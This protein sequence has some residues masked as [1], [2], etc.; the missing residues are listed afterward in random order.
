MKDIVI[1]R[2]NDTPV[3]EQRTEM[4][5]RKGCGHPDSICDAVM[6][7]VAIALAHEYL[8]TFGR[9][10]HFNADKCLLVAGRSE[11]RVGGGTF[12]EPMRLVFGDR[13][14]AQFGNKR[15]D[16]GAVA[17]VAATNWLRRHLRYVDP[18]N[19]LVFQ[20]ELKEGSPELTGIFAGGKAK[21]NDTSVAVGYAPLSETERLVLRCERFLNSATFKARFPEVGEDVKVMGYRRDR[22]LALTVAVA[23]VDRFVPS[24]RAY[25]DRKQ[26]MADAV[27]LELQRELKSIERLAVSLNTLDDRA[28][29]ES[30][31]YLT[32]LGTSA[33][34]GDGGQVGRGNK[35]NGVISL[36][37]PIGTE[38]AAGKNPVSHVGKIYTLFTHHLASRIS[39][40][41]DG[42]CEAYVWLGS[43]IGAPVNEP[44]IFA[45]RLG[46]ETG[47]SLEDV[48]PSVA[49]AMGHGIASIDEFIEQL[50]R[51]EFPVC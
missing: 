11:P 17:E 48:R 28:A 47:C 18:Q 19:H 37:R 3:G 34:G 40:T 43:Q 42:V 8:K 50:V 29:G 32:V 16:P 46:L 36:N 27:T 9:V 10:L 25:F 7:D 22:D 21:A 1:E 6:E 30:G 12:V 31:I 13:A 39:A 5:E 44:A 4:V 35:V 45:A 38:A 23:F 49:A 26:E 14:T 15:I 20:N 41:V 33:E 24:V 51:G 2:S